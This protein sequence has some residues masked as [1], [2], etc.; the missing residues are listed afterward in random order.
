MKGTGIIRRLDEL[1]RI[2]IPKEIRKSLHIKEGTP[3]EISIQENEIKLKKYSPVYELG[4][5]AKSCA[6]ILYDILGVPVYITDLENLVSCA[7][8]K[9]TEQK[10]KQ[11]IKKHIEKRAICN[12]QNFNSSIFEDELINHKN[13]L[14]SPLIIDG[15]VLGSIIVDYKQ[16]T[17]KLLDSIKIAA[18]FASKLAS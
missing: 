4:E 2:V 8:T 14:I 11:P 7:G 13:I 15:D 1:G 12:L 17:Q 16:C 18:M 9:F 6:E 5:N 10:L 3:L